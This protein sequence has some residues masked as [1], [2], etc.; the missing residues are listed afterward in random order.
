VQASSIIAATSNKLIDQ[1]LA[2]YMMAL[3]V[4]TIES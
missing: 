3:S 1:A 2:H 4:L